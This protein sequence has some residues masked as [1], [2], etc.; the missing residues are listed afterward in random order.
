MLQALALSLYATVK[1]KLFVENL[2]NAIDA[3]QNPEGSGASRALGQMAGNYVPYSSLLHNIVTPSVGIPGTAVGPD[4]VMREANSFVSAALSKFPGFSQDFAPRRDWAGD[5]I[6]VHKGLWSNIPGSAANDEVNRLATQQGGSV[7]A[8]ASRVTG[9]A[10]LR[11]ITMAGDRDTESKGRDAYDRYQELAGHPQGYPSLRDA[12]S[13]LIVNPRYQ[14]P[15]R[16][17]S[18]HIRD[19]AIHPDGHCARLPFGCDEAGER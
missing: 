9:G 6:T 8:P 18:G 16:W 3:F 1:D 13:K 7:G 19:Q 12:I 14:A 4:P 15:A 5:P 11:G 17:L 10:D 2:A